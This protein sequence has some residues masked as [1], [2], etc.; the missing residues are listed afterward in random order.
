MWPQI[1]TADTVNQKWNCQPAT[2]INEATV[3]SNY[4]ARNWPFVGNND[5][6]WTNLIERLR[7]RFHKWREEEGN[8]LTRKKNVYFHFQCARAS[9]SETSVA[10]TFPS[11]HSFKHALARIMSRELHGNASNLRIIVENKPP[12]VFGVKTSNLQKT[13]VALQGRF[14]LLVFC[15]LYTRRELF[16]INKINSKTIFFICFFILLQGKEEEK[17][18]FVHVWKYVYFQPCP[19][20]R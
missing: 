5:L 16:K 1:L 6:N 3:Y 9:L 11:L 19:F 20:R 13:Y 8:A 15:F 10:F 7:N 18:L 12:I 14:C 17:F 2:G 4:A